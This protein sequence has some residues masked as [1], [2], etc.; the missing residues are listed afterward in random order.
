MPFS[1]EDGTAE[2]IASAT[3]RAQDVQDAGVVGAATGER[4]EGG[5]RNEDNC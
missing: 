5:D 3:E 4:V 1:K 2:E